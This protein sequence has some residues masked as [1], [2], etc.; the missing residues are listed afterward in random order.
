MDRYP[1][2]ISLITFG[3]FKLDITIYSLT[4]SLT[5]I[6]NVTYVHLQ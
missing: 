6:A 3:R 1:N 2:G 5:V 4:A